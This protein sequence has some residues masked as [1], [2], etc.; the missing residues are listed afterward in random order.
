MDFR[1]RAENMGLV[2]MFSGG[3]LYS[4]QDLNKMEIEIFGSF[5]TVRYVLV[6]PLGRYE[7]GAACPGI[8]N[9]PCFAHLRSLDR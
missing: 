1:G 4:I 7:R 9:T 5:L 8:R 6:K 2:F 3:E